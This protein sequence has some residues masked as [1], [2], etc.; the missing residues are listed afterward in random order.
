MSIILGFVGLVMD[1]RAAVAAAACHG[2]EGQAPLVR[3]DAAGLHDE[4]LLIWRDV[5]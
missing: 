2:S 4:A 5:S 1:R 3:R